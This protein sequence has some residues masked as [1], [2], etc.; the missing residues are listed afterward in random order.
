LKPLPRSQ[1]SV[2]VGKEIF[3]SKQ[4]FEF[5]V[6]IIEVRLKKVEKHLFEKIDP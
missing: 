5:Q 3:R 4:I 2:S 6:E 1:N